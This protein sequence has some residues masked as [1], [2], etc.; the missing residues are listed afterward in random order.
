[1]FFDLI[2]L[3]ILRVL[4]IL[5]VVR[6]PSSCH[7]LSKVDDFFSVFVLWKLRLRLGLG[8]R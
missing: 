2:Y 3:L 1:V 7:R 4:G 5:R 6:R 8:L